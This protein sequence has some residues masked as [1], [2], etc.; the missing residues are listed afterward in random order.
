MKVSLVVLTAGKTAGQAIPIKLSQFL[1]GRDP[2]CH[3]RPASAVISKRHCAVLVKDG[4]VFVRDFGSTNGTF[5]NDAQVDG[6]RELHHDDTLKVGPLTFRVVL[7][8]T[9]PVNKP[10]PPPPKAVEPSDD[11]SVAAMLLSL[12]DDGNS[13]VAGAK[14]GEDGVPEGSTVM[15]IAS[16]LAAEQ[17]A[18]EAE[19]KK[20]PEKKAE[21][22][23]KAMGNTSSA[24]KA[25]LDKYTR[26]PRA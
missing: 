24:A 25:I 16:P 14:V 3:L 22:A 4:K 1:I 26:R 11:E 19:P 6:E 13:P 20:E 17:A 2:Q 15:D 8:A 12:Q 10:T 5:I 9:P 7:E 21:P 23:D 18:R